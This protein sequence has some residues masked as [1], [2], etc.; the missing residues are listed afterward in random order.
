MLGDVDAVEL[1]PGQLV[2]LRGRL[3]SRTAADV[4]L[5]LHAALDSGVGDLRVDLAE[6]LV[7]DA[8]GLG[9]VVGVHRRAARSGRRLV[10]VGV[11]ARTE[12]LIRAARLQRVLVR[13][14]PAVLAS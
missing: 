8:T 14:R 6:A 11:D 9:L 2:V 1:V 4:R 12:R 7:G 13:D 5:A 10:L 3:D